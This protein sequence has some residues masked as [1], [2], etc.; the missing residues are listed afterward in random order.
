MT[1]KSSIAEKRARWAKGFTLVELI[2]VVG[3]LSI[4]LAIVMPSLTQA[5]TATF[6]KQARVEATA[7]AQAAIRYKA[8]Y[9]FWPGEVV[10]DSDDS[11]KIHP[12]SSDTQMYGA[13]I[14]GP[15]SF[16]Q[17]IETREGMDAPAILHLNTNEVFQ[18]FSTVGYPEGAGYKR[19]PLNP[20]MI[21]FLD[22][23]NETDFNNVNFVDPWGESYR[24]VMGLNPRSRFTFTVKNG[25]VSLY[26]VSVSNVTAFAFSLGPS[27]LRSTNYIYSAGVGE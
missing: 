8:E 15:E 1:S 26:E 27:S 14:A 4:L 3:V 19:N 18:A 23:K 7:L 21:S 2:I 24:L 11:V 16:T 17:N 9:G 10:W 22:L 20:K 12:N 5:R 6:K 13:I 25:E